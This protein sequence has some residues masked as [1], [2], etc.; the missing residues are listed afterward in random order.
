M[1]WYSEKYLRSPQDALNPLF[2]PIL[3][4]DLSR[5]PPALILTAQYDPLRDQ[6]EAYGAKLAEAG[7]PVTVVRFKG[8]IHGF[9]GNPYKAGRDALTF[10]GAVLRDAFYS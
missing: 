6:G 5:L 4:K 9:L 8:V 1:A 3:N 10:M 7:V 2:A